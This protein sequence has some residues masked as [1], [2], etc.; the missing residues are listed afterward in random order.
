MHSGDLLLHQTQSRHMPH[1]FH[2]LLTMPLALLIYSLAKPQD[3]SSREILFM[4]GNTILKNLIYRPLFSH[5]CL[6]R[7]V[8]SNISTLLYHNF[9]DNNY[10]V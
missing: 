1:T 3:K 8:T 9:Y 4:D 5:L 6:L 10:C 7:P 2:S